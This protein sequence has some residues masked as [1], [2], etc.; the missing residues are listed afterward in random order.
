[1][2]TATATASNTGPVTA[3]AQVVVVP[4][5]LTITKTPD[6]GTVN[7]GSSIGF[8]ITVGNSG[9]GMARSVTLDDPLP[10][11]DG[12]SWA[13]DN[14]PG[15]GTCAVNGSAPSQTLHCDFGDLGVTA[16][17]TVHI[18]SSTSFVSCATYPNIATAA[19]TN[20]SPASATASTTVQCPAL[21]LTKTADNPVVN[22]GSDLG[23]TITLS[24]SGPGTATG[25]SLSDP[26]P[27]G[28]GI[29]W[30]LDD[31]SKAAGCAVV[32]VSVQ[33]AF[34]SLT[35]GNSLSVHLTT[36]TE[37]ATCGQYVNQAS[38][39]A[40][41]H[42][43]VQAQATADVQCP[44]LSITKTAD[45]TPVNTGDQIG[46]TVTVSNAGPGIATNVKVNDPLPSGNGV[47]WSID[48]ANEDCSIDGAPPAQ[49]LACTFGDLGA[50][51]SASV[52]IISA[53]TA[54][55]GGTYDNTATATSDNAP[56][57][58]ASATVVVQPPALSITKTADAPQVDAGQKIGFTV[59]VSNSDAEGTGI[60]RA[61][62]LTD[63]L[64][65]GNGVNWSIDPAYAGPGTCSISGTAPKQ[66]L[67]C[68][69]GDMDPGASASVHVSSATTDAS[70]GNYDN[71]AV[72]AT[73]NGSSVH[74]S[75]TTA[76]NENA[77][78][79]VEAT[80]TTTTTTVPPPP[81]TLPFTGSESA[82]LGVIGLVLVATG[83]ALF[84]SRR[85]R[86]AAN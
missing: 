29:N 70:V 16:S 30:S 77:P 62:T 13:I 79:V 35:A 10:G 63:P 37:F 6:A 12:V 5:A 17:V 24:N 59:T 52:H 65:G 49:T 33:C 4:P 60:A 43:V 8:T 19:T 39:Q 47:N 38:A 50:E 74:A 2:N 14:N 18:T 73:T 72:A 22:A 71:T 76:V 51:S 58:N 84:L 46:F 1:V 82:R 81:P 48:P 78:V 11:H 34:G 7:A 55:S 45:A 44:D 54:A 56:S 67:G 85:R 26:L 42:P 15:I 68:S 3:T 25:V 28:T 21:D 23:F 9:P 41:N 69:F 40:S 27:T 20:G 57:V 53:T 36:P 86:R 66:T 31:A 83:T 32:A 80:T 61:V 64:P 75:A